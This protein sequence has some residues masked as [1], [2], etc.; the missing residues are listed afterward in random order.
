LAFSTRPLVPRRL[1]ASLFPVAVVV[2]V[3]LVLA[4]A[5]YPFFAIALHLSAF[6]V[7]ALACHLELAASR[8]ASES[9]TEFYLWL[10]AGGAVG[11]IFNT[12][13]A[14]LLFVNPFE[15][16]LAALSA[17]LLLPDANGASGAAETARPRKPLAGDPA[18]KASA[19]AAAATPVTFAVVVTL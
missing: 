18:A 15:Y 6:F 13:V 12:L 2:V 5:I 17:C 3:A 4:P 16:P 10:S 7:I 8:P 19:S 9:L 14:P 1:V 11:G